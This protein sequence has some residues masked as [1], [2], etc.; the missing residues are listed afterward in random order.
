[1]KAKILKIG[2][3][4]DGKPVGWD[5]DCMG[6]VPAVQV[7]NDGSTLW[8]GYS[9]EELQEIAARPSEF[10]ELLWNGL[11]M[12]L[13]TEFTENLRYEG[14]GLTAYSLVIDCGGYEGR[15]AKGIMDLYPG[16]CVV[17]F[18]PIKE[19]YERTRDALEFYPNATVIHA[20]VGAT[21]RLEFFGVQGDRTGIFNGEPTRELVELYDLPAWIKELG[22]KIQ[23]LKLNIEGGEFEVIPALISSN[24]IHE[25]ENLQVQFHNLEADSERRYK[26]IRNQLGATHE[27]TYWFPFVWENWRLK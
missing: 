18:E 9:I 22:R 7:F 13:P 10:T 2:G 11:N 6:S 27:L 4:T 15:F 5:F 8:A 20:G 1:M 3:F 21:S 17:V 26:G 14:Y 19:F 24:V 23:L 12:K 16:C 25:I